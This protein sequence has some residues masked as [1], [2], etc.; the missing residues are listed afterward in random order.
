MPFVFSV[1]RFFFFF[2]KN[3]F[4][5]FKLRNCMYSMIKIQVFYPKKKKKNYD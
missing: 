4:Q 3:V 1:K 2:K 5:I